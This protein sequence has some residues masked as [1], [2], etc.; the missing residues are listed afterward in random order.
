MDLYV[1][2]NKAHHLNIVLNALFFWVNG[3][4][5]TKT[6]LRINFA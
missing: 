4:Q 1:P 5:F 3:N 2:K 6:Y